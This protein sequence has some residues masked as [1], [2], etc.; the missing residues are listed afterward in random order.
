MMY[1]IY[2]RYYNQPYIDTYNMYFYYIVILFMVKCKFINDTY[3]IV[4][5]VYIN[6]DVYN[7]WLII[8]YQYLTVAYKY[9]NILVYFRKLSNFMWL[10]FYSIW[11][12]RYI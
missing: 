3:I 9:D 4:G 2:I 5:I 12:H 8:Y 10:S 6:K 11:L 7:M 1:L